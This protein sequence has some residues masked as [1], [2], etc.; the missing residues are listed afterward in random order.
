MN[1][2]EVRCSGLGKDHT[3]HHFLEYTE[4]WGHFDI[5][6]FPN[7]DHLRLVTLRRHLKS[8][9]HL[10]CLKL[11]NDTNKIPRSSH[12]GIRLSKLFL[13]HS[14]RW[15][16]SAYLNMPIYNE[17]P[18]Q[19]ASHLLLLHFFSAYLPFCKDLLCFRVYFCSR[20]HF[21]SCA[22]NI[23]HMSWNFVLFCQFS[24]HKKHTYI[25]YFSVLLYFSFVL[26]GSTTGFVSSE[27]SLS[28]NIFV[29]CHC[30]VLQLYN[31]LD[32]ILMQRSQKSCNP[33]SWSLCCVVSLLFW[34]VR[35]T[36]YPLL[37]YIASPDV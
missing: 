9:A 16:L 29:F 21:V 31:I 23:F 26:A 12:F 19:I 36:M 14:I 5:L 10:F 34:R 37:R 25:Y 20:L 13:D 3:F 15:K 24:T 35:Q 18:F 22:S 6:S 27:L 4:W 30:E 17:F 28:Q 8:D 32:F 7:L 2:H 11:T 1:P 33:Y